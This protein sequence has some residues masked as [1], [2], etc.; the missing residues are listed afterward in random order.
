M[1]DIS[2]EQ[3]PC[4][5]NIKTPPVKLKTPSENRPYKNMSLNK[6]YVLDLAQSIPSKEEMFNRYKLT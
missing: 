3:I 2:P 1:P 4:P 5:V 6:D